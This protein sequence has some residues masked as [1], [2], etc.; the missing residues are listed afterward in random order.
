MEVMENSLSGEELDIVEVTDLDVGAD[1]QIF[2][3]WTSSSATSNGDNIPID[4]D[5][6]K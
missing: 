2:I 5:I 3:D 4:E 6:K 1:I